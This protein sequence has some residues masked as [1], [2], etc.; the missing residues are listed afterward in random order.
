MS[1]WDPSNSDAAL[2][3]DVERWRKDLAGWQAAG[4]IHTEPAETIKGWIASVE[5]LLADR[6]ASRS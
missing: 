3:R 6:N 5:Q 4:L 2:R 1:I